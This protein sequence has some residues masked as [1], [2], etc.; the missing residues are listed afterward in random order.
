M[1]AKELRELSKDELQAKA[2]D[3][4]EKKYRL[5]FQHGIRSLDNT[6]GIQ[7]IKKDIARIKTVMREK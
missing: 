5:K 4:G 7:Q 6:A 3:L 1:K 2:K